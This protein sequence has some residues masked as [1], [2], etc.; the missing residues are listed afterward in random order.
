MTSS[1]LAPPDVSAAAYPRNAVIHDLFFAQA[2]STPDAVAIEEGAT[3]ITYGELATRARRLAV[4]LREHGAGPGEIVA[5][6]EA[7]SIAVVTGLIA[8]LETGAAYL[9][10]D[11]TWPRARLQTIIDDAKPC[12]VLSNAPLN[13]DGPRQVPLHAGADGGRIH[14]SVEATDPAYITYTSG[15]T[16]TPKGVCIPHRGVVRLVRETNYANFDATEVFLHLAPL[17]FDAST[18]EIWGSLLNGARL[19]LLPARTPSLEQI[20]DIIARH[21]VTTVFLTSALFRQMAE[22]HVEGFRSLRLLLTGGEMASS[23]HFERVLKHHPHLRIGHVYGP[24]ETTTFATCHHLHSPED[25]RCTPL[26]IGRAISHSTAYVIKNDNSVAGPG[27]E[28]E[29]YLGGDGLAI[30]YWNRPDLTERA[31][32]SADVSPVPGERLYKTGDHCLINE[33][34]LIVFLGRFDRQVKVRGFRIELEEIEHALASQP[35]VAEAVVKVIDRGT[36]D[37]MLAAYISPKAGAIEPNA[38]LDEQ[39]A[40]NRVRQWLEIYESIIYRTLSERTHAS[41]DPSFNFTGWKSSY[42]GKYLS[43]DEMS[44]QVQ[45]AID[46]ILAAKP[47]SVLEIGCG[48][49]MLLFKIAPF[50]EH[51]EA[52]DFSRAAIDFVRAHLNGRDF[53]EHVHLRHEPADQLNVTR[54][55]DAVVLNSVVQHFPSADYLRRLLQRV[56]PQ[57]NDGG[58]IF[59]GDVRSLPLAGMF[60]ASLAEHRGAPVEEEE[61]LLLDPRFFEAIDLPRVSGVRALLKRGVHHNEL[62]RFRYDVVL[63]VGPSNVNSHFDTLAWDSLNSIAAVRELLPSSIRITDIPNRRLTS[64]GI[65]PED[66]W[67][68]ENVQVEIRPTPG[69]TDGRY[70]VD[71]VPTGQ[72]ALSPPVNKSSGNYANDPLRPQRKQHV[73]RLVR[74]RLAASLPG[75]MLPAFLT[76]LDRLPMNAN[77]KVDHAQ[78]PLPPVLEAT[79]TSVE[80]EMTVTESQLASLW[81]I[82]LGVNAVGPG[83]H[84]FDLGG[85]SLKAVRLSSL[86]RPVFTAALTPA[87]VFDRPTLR[88][89]AQ[90]IDGTTVQPSTAQS[91]GAQR[92]ARL[93]RSS[94]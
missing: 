1:V 63:E 58:R 37:K 84:F 48:S 28:G 5:I 42:D 68:L 30:G 88:A 13:A 74:E 52:T 87:I 62:T 51:Y 19:V 10:L 61:E 6:A 24:T 81:E 92:R 86:A 7:R 25:A 53:A 57:V 34:G 54:T 36:P 46:R 60:Y 4:V 16:G 17:A 20:G 41:A 47:R 72:P 31:F 70:D 65:D 9:P 71:I 14:A 80:P 12:C 49:G 45:Q 73:A 64:D 32:V 38:E 93:A 15:S 56:I 21:G 78:L 23:R 66:F 55:F 85:D 79:R 59:L 2:A 35:E 76:V 75:Y 11:A 90:W 77:G 8:I 27:E 29:L 26:P 40:A 91:R 44:E 22:H 67:A 69:A 18:F 3:R 94:S 89:L 83:D 39:L 43:A 33:D 82:V 50:V